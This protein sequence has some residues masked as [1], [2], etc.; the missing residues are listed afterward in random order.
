MG[1]FRIRDRYFSFCKS[2]FSFHSSWRMFGRYDLP[3]KNWTLRKIN[4]SVSATERDGLVSDLYCWNKRRLQP[5]QSY[6]SVFSAPGYGGSRLIV[7]LHVLFHLLSPLFYCCAVC[8][9]VFHRSIP[10]FRHFYVKTLRKTC[11]QEGN[12]DLQIEATTQACLSLFIS[13]F[14]PSLQVLLYVVFFRR[15]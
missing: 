10:S 15:V 6:P 1:R 5:V 4:T 13:P 2:Y 3:L 7:Q 12:F 14:L 8:R 11:W 9:Y